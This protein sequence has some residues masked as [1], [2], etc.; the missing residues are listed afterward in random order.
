MD[1][2][3]NKNIERYSDGERGALSWICSIALW[4]SNSLVQ[5]EACLIHAI[6]IPVLV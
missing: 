3:S 5:T 1:M 6:S 4:I 2:Q